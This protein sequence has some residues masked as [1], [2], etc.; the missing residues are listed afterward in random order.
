MVTFDKVTYEYVRRDEE[1]N[2][3]STNKAL[4]EVSLKIKQGDFV[5]VLGSNG[6]GKSTFAK[7]INALLEPTEGDVYVLENNTK[8][9]DKH[10]EIHQNAGMVFQNPD[11]QIVASIVEE[12]VAFG[13]ENMGVPTEELR[14]RVDDALRRVGMSEYHDRTPNKLSGGQKQRI[15][16][17]G[18]L[19]MKPKCIVLD[20]PTAMLD[21]EGRRE[22][23]ETIHDLNKNEH[24]TVVLITHYMQEAVE[25][26][27]IFVMNNGICVMEGTPRE[28]FS[29]VEKLKEY[30]LDVPQVTELAYRLRQ[31]GVNMPECVLTEDEFVEAVTG[32]KK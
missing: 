12:D 20:E 31:S 15:A 19:A 22:V 23:I 7:H 9:E 3:V 4:K 13:P 28:V 24:I 30:K 26:D 32:L 17:A 1:G 29:Q 8:D 25:A 14:L 6:S 11:N 5:V 16:I 27:R 18:I 21:P 10:F 2:V